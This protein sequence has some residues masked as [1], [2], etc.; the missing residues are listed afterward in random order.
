MTLHRTNIALATL[1]S[2]ALLAAAACTRPGDERAL[3]EVSIGQAELADASLRVEG[4]LANV[5]HFTDYRVELWSQSPVLAIQLELGPTAAGTWSL[6]IRNAMPDAVLDVA[7]TTHARLADP[8]RHPTVAVFEVP[9][10]AGSH[11]LRVASPDA[12]M[13]EPHRFAAMADIQTALPEVHEVF[14]AINAVPG[15]RYVVGMGDITQRSLV[16]EY[17]LFERQLLVLHVPFYTTLG[18]HE[19][20]SDPSRF[21]ERYGRASFQFEFKGVTFTFADS[22]NAGIDPI[23]EDWLDGWLFD[24]ARD[25]THIF[26]THF[27]PIDP[28]AARYGGF[29]SNDD[30]RRLLAR[31]ARSDVD[32]TLYGH[33]HTYIEFE[34]AGI[35]AYVSGGGGADPMRWDGIDRHFLVID[36]DDRG[37]QRVRG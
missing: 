18:N 27:P 33:I 26:L 25:R 11:V 14:A 12:G 10:A 5:K 15:I 17:E 13:L 31:L 16:D 4:G 24:S 23:V 34:N 30:A 37:I 2:L 21:H 29:R 7:G 19:L 9:L 6:T 32:L 8:D 35:P 28:V 36:A 22:G 3:L 20:W 1:A